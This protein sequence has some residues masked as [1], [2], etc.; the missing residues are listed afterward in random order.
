MFSARAALVGE[1]AHV[2]PPLAAQGL[3]LSLRD[4]ATLTQAVEDARGVGLDFGSAQ[5]LEPYGRARRGDVALRAH[6]VDLL[7]RSFLAGLAPVDLARSL[8][9]AAFSAIGPLRRALMRE[10]VLTHGSL[11]RLMQAGSARG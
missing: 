4:V 2:F 8:G 3:N 6:G 1:A 11:P 10:G 9:F 7:N 5:A